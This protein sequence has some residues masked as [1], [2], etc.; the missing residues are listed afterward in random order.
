MVASAESSRTLARVSGGTPITDTANA[1]WRCLDSAIGRHI[2]AR[3]NLSPEHSDDREHDGQGL[4]GCPNR[5]GDVRRLREG[6]S[7]WRED[8][9]R[10]DGAGRLLVRGVRRLAID[11]V[12]A[13]QG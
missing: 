11:D 4:S 7:A 3:G 8:E 5:C 12:S 1:E 13:L 9:G 10:G 2:C 6:L